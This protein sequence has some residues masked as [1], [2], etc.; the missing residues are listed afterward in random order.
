MNYS[1]HSKNGVFLAYYIYEITDVNLVDDAK[2]YVD[3]D[4]FED[5]VMV[6]LKNELFNQLSLEIGN[7]LSSDNIRQ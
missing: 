5:L 3:L 1:R 6:D 7:F 2:D 4:L